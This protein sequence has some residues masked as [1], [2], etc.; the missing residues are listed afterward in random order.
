MD[1]NLFASETASNDTTAIDAVTNDAANMAADVN[2]ANDIE[3]ND[4]TANK[5]SNAPRKSGGAA[6]NSSTNN[7]L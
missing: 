3:A 5:P 4:M 2:Y 6:A 1:E 7:M